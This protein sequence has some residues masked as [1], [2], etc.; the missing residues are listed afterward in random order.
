MQNIREVLEESTLEQPQLEY[1]QKG[2]KK[3]IH[4]EHLGYLLNDM[5][6][7]QRTYPNMKW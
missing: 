5:Q 1:F 7:M 3:G 2:G 6:F 4:S